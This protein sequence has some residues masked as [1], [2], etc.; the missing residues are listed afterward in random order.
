MCIFF[1]LF[2]GMLLAVL[3]SATVEESKHLCDKGEEVYRSAPVT[4]EILTK[5][6]DQLLTVLAEN[7]KSDEE[8]NEKNRKA[9]EEKYEKNRKADRDFLQ[10]FVKVYK[11]DRKDDE[12]KYE[13]NRKDDEEKYEKYRK[14]DRAFIY[15]LF[16]EKWSAQ[17][18][19]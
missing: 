1:L 4:H 9:D 12:E 10:D 2:L 11:K 15:N 8:K 13:K 3:A 6:F 5:K 14:E 19:P 17:H 18:S 7:R 16:S